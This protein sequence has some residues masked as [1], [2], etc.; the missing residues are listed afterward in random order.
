MKFKLIVRRI[1]HFKMVVSV[2]CIMPGRIP[3]TRINS[4][5]PGTIYAELIDDDGGRI[6][7]LC[8]VEELKLEGKDDGGSWWFVAKK[9]DR[10]CDMKND[11]PKGV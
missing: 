7:R 10:E 8:I 9:K 1:R 4:F 5:Y 2:P 6:M 11:Y 3:T